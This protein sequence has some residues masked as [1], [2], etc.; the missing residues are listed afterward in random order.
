MSVQGPPVKPGHRAGFINQAMCRSN[1]K[2][3]QRRCGPSPPGSMLAVSPPLA[4]SAS[5]RRDGGAIA[6][7]V[8]RMMLRPRA[9]AARGV[10]CSRGVSDNLRRQSDTPRRQ[11]KTGLLN[12]AILSKH[13]K[14]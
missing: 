8:A 10:L 1:C 11:Y 3:P 12:L 7:A 13:R 5:G 9:T 4:A 6:G 2:F 14:A